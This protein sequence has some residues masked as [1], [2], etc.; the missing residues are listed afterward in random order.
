MNEAV[1]ATRPQ[2]LIGPR[3]AP[4][5][6]RFPWGVI[7]E[8]HEVGPYQ[9]AQYRKDASTYA[10]ESA[11]VDHGKTMFH[12]Y[13]EGKDACQSFWTLDAALVG[14]IAYRAEGPNGQAAEYFMRMIDRDRER[15]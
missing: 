1:T 3:T 5:G 12:I 10:H 9:I 4:D 8:V 13:V 15:E 7:D 11:W 2:P 6:K 14:A